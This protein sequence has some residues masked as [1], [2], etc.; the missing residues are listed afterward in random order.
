MKNGNPV[1]FESGMAGA[2]T[3]FQLCRG[4]RSCVADHSRLLTRALATHKLLV[5][6][7]QRRSIQGLDH[8]QLD[9]VEWLDLQA[10][11]GPIAVLPARSCYN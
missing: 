3:S 11:Y 8:G 10:T 1:S 9:P 2:K 4:R 5:C 6:V 7:A